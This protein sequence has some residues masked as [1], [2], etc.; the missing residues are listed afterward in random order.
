MTGLHKDFIIWPPSHIC[1]VCVMKKKKKEKKIKVVN[2][3]CCLTGRNI[4][5]L[6]R[7]YMSK[8]LFWLTYLCRYHIF[9]FFSFYLI[10]STISNVPQI[11]TVHDCLTLSHLSCENCGCNFEKTFWMWQQNYFVTFI[12]FSYCSSQ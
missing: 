7:F 12:H 2:I 8:G 5:L 3:Q 10:P 11:L 4:L 1:F 9:I 6:E